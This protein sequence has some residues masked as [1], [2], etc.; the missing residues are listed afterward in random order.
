MRAI[1]IAGCITIDF[2]YKYLFQSNLFN[3]I[4]D[5]KSLYGLFAINLIDAKAEQDV[6]KVV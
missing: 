6:K 2:F 5:I 3:L 4:N 1:N